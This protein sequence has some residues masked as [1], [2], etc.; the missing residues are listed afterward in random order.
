MLEKPAPSDVLSLPVAHRSQRISTA[1]SRS[2]VDAPSSPSK[3]SRRWAVLRAAFLFGAFR[4]SRVHPSNSA[5]SKYVHKPKP[6][7]STLEGA[8]KE[9]AAAITIQARW[10]GRMTRDELYWEMVSKYSSDV[11][12]FSDGLQLTRCRATHRWDIDAACEARTDCHE[13]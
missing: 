1:S 3:P 10:R 13:S 7:L 11:E 6:P 4:S 9:A 2:N 5:A 12:M 8:V